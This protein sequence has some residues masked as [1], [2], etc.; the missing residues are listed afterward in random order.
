[1]TT[2]GYGDYY[3]RTLSGRLVAFALCVWGTIIVSLIIVSLTNYLQYDNKQKQ[4]DFMSKKLKMKQEVLEASAALIGISWRCYYNY[5][6]KKSVLKNI[7]FWINNRKFKSAFT[8]LK[9][10]KKDL[11]NHVIEGDIFDRFIVENDLIRNDFDDLFAKNEEIYKGAKQLQSQIRSLTMTQSTDKLLKGKE[12]NDDKEESDLSLDKYQC[13]F[14]SCMS[15]GSSISD[16]TR[17]PSPYKKKQV[18]SDQELEK[19]LE[20]ERDDSM[21]MINFDE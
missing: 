21:N 19:E 2:I 5:V 12:A 7:R 16:M 14:S 18:D 3:P 6:G 17:P 15:R 4:A 20:G 13:A 9:N 1:M 11:R 8:R 10:A